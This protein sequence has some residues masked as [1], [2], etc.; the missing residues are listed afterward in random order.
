MPAL[1]QTATDAFADLSIPI[2]P[3]APYLR[4]AASLDADAHAVPPPSPAIALQQRLEHAVLASF[5]RPAVPRG[6]AD[7]R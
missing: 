2:E 5:F 7:R 1:R 3:G 4:D 6:R